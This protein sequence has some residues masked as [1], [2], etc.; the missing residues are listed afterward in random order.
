VEEA[1]RRRQELNEDAKRRQA[2]EEEARRRRAVEGELSENTLTETLIL[3]NAQL[4]FI[5]EICV[6]MKMISGKV[7]RRFLTVIYLLLHRCI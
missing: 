3:L 5:P 4:I 1:A 2:V 6:R 7:Y